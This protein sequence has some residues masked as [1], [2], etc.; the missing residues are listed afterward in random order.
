M[1][2]H[3]AT[4]ETKPFDEFV[5]EDG[6]HFLIDGV[7]QRVYEFSN[8][9]QVSVLTGDDPA[10]YATEGRADVGMIFPGVDDI[11]VYPNVDQAEQLASILLDA[12]AMEVE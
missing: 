11:R 6:P 4:T 1:E 9:V 10:I 8:G 3:E 2:T 5:I 7:N 12:Q